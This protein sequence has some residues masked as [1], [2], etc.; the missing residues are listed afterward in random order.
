LCG[1]G[2]VGTTGG[3][4]G[5]ATCRAD[6]GCKCGA[7]FVAD[8]E[9]DCGAGNARNF[10]EAKTNDNIWIDQL[11]KVKSKKELQILLKDAMD[12]SQ[13][14][15]PFCTMMFMQPFNTRRHM[16]QQSCI[17]IKTVSERIKQL[18]KTRQQPP[19]SLQNDGCRYFRVH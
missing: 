16:D 6:G 7:D 5:G 17:F 9:A 8:D 10:P 15:C 11:E 3:V 1:I 13:L 12:S 4:D 14:T 18:S 19:A 2:G